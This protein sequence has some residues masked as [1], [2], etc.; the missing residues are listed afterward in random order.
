M[1][2]S[3]MNGAAVPKTAVDEDG[4]LLSHEDDVGATP[5][6]EQRL[7]VDL[8]PQPHGVQHLSHGEFR[9]CARSAL[10]AHPPTDGVRGS[11]GFAPTL[12]HGST[13]APE[14]RQLGESAA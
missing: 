8:V 11:E 4:N 14:P 3:T 1:A 13:V 2:T 12:G 10:G 6:I 5:E 7:D 9:A